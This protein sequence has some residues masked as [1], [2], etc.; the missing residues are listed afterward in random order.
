MSMYVVANKF[1]LLFVLLYL[2]SHTCTA[3]CSTNFFRVEF[4]EIKNYI[5]AEWKVF[6]I[7]EDLL[8]SNTL[9]F[10]DGSSLKSTN[11]S[12]TTTLVGEAGK[13]DYKEG[14]GTDAEFYF[15]TDFVQWNATTIVLVDINN[16][17]LRVADRMRYETS[18]L[19]GMC[20]RPGFKDG[21]GTEA[22]FDYPWSVIKDLKSSN[23]LLVTDKDNDAIRQVDVLS[24]MVMTLIEKSVG[25]KRPSG[26]TF[27]ALEENL[28]ITNMYGVS[29]YNLASRNYTILAG[30]DSDFGKED[31]SLADARFLYPAALIPL[32]PD[33]ILVAG[34]TN[35]K[36]RV[37]NTVDD[38]V[39]SIC[40]GVRGTKSGLPDVCELQEPSGL[41]VKDGRIYVGQSHA[42]STIPCKYSEFTHCHILGCFRA[43][44]MSCLYKYVNISGF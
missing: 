25:L 37:L 21:A 28:L 30:K 32:S 22:R 9:L 19:V 7:E 20:E 39:S 13:L 2:L 16:H 31:G 26:I 15:I 14:N 10:T 42:I 1:E 11:G 24:R 5:D 4:G 6:H 43:T 33:V 17:C 18:T 38:S 40:T 44:A 8:D 27:D 35:N 29:R 34:T 23:K 36:L 3:N 41:L 12:M